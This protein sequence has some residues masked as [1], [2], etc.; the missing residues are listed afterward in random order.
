MFF[1]VQICICPF[2]PICFLPPTS[3]NP[4][5]RQNGSKKQIYCF[6]TAFPGHFRSFN[7]GVSVV[8]FFCDGHIQLVRQNAVDHLVGRHPE[9]IGG[10]R[11]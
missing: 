2:R 4:D 8:D 9:L 1:Q 6:T 5:F 11:I 3:G 10:F 7:T